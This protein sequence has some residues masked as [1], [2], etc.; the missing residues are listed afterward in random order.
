MKLFLVIV[1]VAITA[2]LIHVCSFNIGEDVKL[3]DINLGLCTHLKVGHV[4]IAGDDHWPIVEPLQSHWEALFNE[5]VQLREIFPKMK[6]ILKVTNLYNSS[7]NSVMAR[8]NTPQRV[9]MRRSL[10][11][12]IEQFDF[13]GLDFEL[14]RHPVTHE[15]RDLLVS[16]RTLMRKDR[17]RKRLITYT[18]MDAISASMFKKVELKFVGASEPVTKFDENPTRGNASDNPG[19]DPDMTPFYPWYIRRYIGN[20]TPSIC[21]ALDWLFVNPFH[22][23]VYTFPHRIDV[24]S[25]VAYIAYRDNWPDPDYEIRKN[26]EPWRT[27]SLVFNET[28]QMQ[29]IDEIVD[30][31]CQSEKIVMELTS[32]KNAYQGQFELLNR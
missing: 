6:I 9:V 21:Q 29:L 17:K 13:D 27:L 1:N 32:K 10:V 14:A 18:P 4:R 28:Y 31:G 7:F 3:E 20:L 11:N 23:P 22:D 8:R 16:M 5:T 12:Y 2:K 19:P 30:N 15:F 25:N 26:L 24:S